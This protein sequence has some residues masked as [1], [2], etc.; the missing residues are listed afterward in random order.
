VTA[1][2]PTDAEAV[3]APVTSNCR[4]KDVS[5]TADL[6]YSHFRYGG[7]NYED[8]AGWNLTTSPADYAR[9]WANGPGGNPWTVA[10]LNG[11]EM[12]VYK[13]GTTNNIV[14][15][16]YNLSGN[17]VPFGATFVSI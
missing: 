5:A 3:T 9:D 10:M 15:Y 12:G 7:A 11:C 4:G 6:C 1:D 13:A 17:H 2:L 16:K 14:V 8:P